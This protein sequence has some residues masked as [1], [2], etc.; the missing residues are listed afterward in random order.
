M[1]PPKYFGQR[2]RI[3]TLQCILSR[4]KVFEIRKVLSDAVH[5]HDAQYFY[6]C[7]YLCPL[8]SWKS[9]VASHW[10]SNMSLT[11][12]YRQQNLDLRHRKY[13]ETQI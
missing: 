3:I 12:K 6:Y 7:D 1:W 9:F 5:S 4:K 8:I 10:I 11:F 13:E 2:N